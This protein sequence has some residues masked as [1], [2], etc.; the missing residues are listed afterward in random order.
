METIGCPGC[1]AA[2]RRQAL[3]RKPDGTLELDICFEC[4]SI[5]FDR[6]ESSQLTAGA[7]IELFRLIHEGASSDARPMS[8]TARCPRCRQALLA[9]H[10]I[11]RTTPFTYFRCP[12]WHG[13][14]ITF[15]QFLREKN[16]VRSLSAA[17]VARLRATVTQVRCSSCGAPVDVEKGAACEYCHAPLAILDADAVRRT[18]AELST[19]ERRRTV[20]DPAAAIDALLAGQHTARRITR[21]EQVASQSGVDLVLE[22][23]AALS[24]HF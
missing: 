20:P 3:A 21:A 8:S 16:F 14:L 24:V 5:W 4:Q 13:R 12:Q 6:F 10:D 9:T 1:G 22:A 19:E 18:L 15:F 17:E 23:I 11:Q 2:M 7:T